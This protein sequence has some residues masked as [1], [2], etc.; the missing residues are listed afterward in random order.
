MEIIAKMSTDEFLEFMEWKK[1][2]NC[3]WAD[4]DA[5]RKK[6]ETFA[7]KVCYALD[8]DPKRP[9]KVKIID[10][11]YAAELLEMAKEFFD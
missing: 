7:S 6:W 9:G 3:Y 11:E 10:Q 4:L 2:R 8:N 1:D 5:T